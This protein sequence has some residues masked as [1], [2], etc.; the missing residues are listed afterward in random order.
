M[1]EIGDAA[2]ADRVFLLLI[3]AHEHA[4]PLTILRARGLGTPL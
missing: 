2:T 4:R 1:I 3:I